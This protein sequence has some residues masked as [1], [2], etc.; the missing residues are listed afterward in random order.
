MQRSGVIM[1]PKIC[2]K[3]N[4]SKMLRDWTETFR[5][6]RMNPRS[7]EKQFHLKYQSRSLGFCDWQILAEGVKPYRCQY[8]HHRGYCV[9]SFTCLT[10]QL[11]NSS[12][13]GET[14]PDWCV[15]SHFL[16]CLSLVDNQKIKEETW[17]GK[18]FIA[19]LKKMSNQVC[20]ETD[21]TLVPFCCGILRN[22]HCSL[23]N[24]LHLLSLQLKI[25]IEA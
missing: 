6:E 21:F 25:N 10:L 9:C 13:L 20:L 11:V 23:E 24:K 22:A 7:P 18:R 3:A 2:Y 14:M 17:N 8:P 19:V 16:L 15:P 4:L 12:F 1:W 5:M